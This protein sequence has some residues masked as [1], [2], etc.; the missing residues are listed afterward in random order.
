VT[1]PKENETM[2]DIDLDALERAA[3]AAFRGP[4]R[5]E[6]WEV[7]CEDADEGGDDC[8]E[9]GENH[10][11]STVT[12]PDQYPADEE[13]PQVVAQIDEDHGGRIRTPGL[14]QFARANALHIATASPDVI[15][16]L[17]AEVRRLRCRVDELEDRH[18][19]LLARTMQQAVELRKT[20][21]ERDRMTELL[22]EDKDRR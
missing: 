21:A 4:W 9:Y 17:V 13:N 15:L 2:S 5:A 19:A 12:A 20:E 11:V 10:T 1:Q 6:R 22:H 8:D 14:E 7:A 16:A 18:N 3:K